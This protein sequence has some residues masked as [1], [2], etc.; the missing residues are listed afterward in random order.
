MAMVTEEIEATPSPKEARRR[1]LRLGRTQRVLQI[2]FGIQITG[3]TPCAQDTVQMPTPD[4]TMVWQV[5]VAGGPLAIQ[6]TIQMVEAAT[7][8][9]SS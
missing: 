6:P 5:P 3:A 9:T 7:M 1:D 8:Q 2:I 4:I